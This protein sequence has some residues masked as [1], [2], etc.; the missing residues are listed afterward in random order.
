MQIIELDVNQRIS[1]RKLPTNPAS[2]GPRPTEPALQRR[3]HPLRVQPVAPDRR[4]HLHVL[5]RG[6]R[7]PA[8]PAVIEHPV[9]RYR[10]AD[11]Y[12]R[13]CAGEDARLLD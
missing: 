1:E 4:L 13:V 7:L 12:L 10:R 11:V 5:L 8:A 6:Q 2:T 3:A 9:G